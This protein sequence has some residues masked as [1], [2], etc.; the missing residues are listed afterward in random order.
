MSVEATTRESQTSTPIFVI[1]PARSGSTLLRYLL[2][3]HPDVSC[4]AET[5]L[6]FA[7]QAIFHSHSVASGDPGDTAKWEPVAIETCRI[8]AQRT[9][10]AAAQRDNKP[11]WCD[12]SLSTAEHASL[13]A[14][15][16]PDVQFL[17]LY[18]RCSDFVASALEAC[19]WGLANFGFEPFVRDTPTNL[20]L[21]LVRYWIDRVERQITAEQHH[22]AS[23]L[24]ITY[25]SLVMDHASTLKAVCAF[26]AIEYRAEFFRDDLV[27][28]VPPTF[29]PED[30]KIAFA[31]RR[32]VESVGRGEAVP[33]ESLVPPD[34][35]TKVASLE[36]DLGLDKCLDRLDGSASNGG[37]GGGGAVRS[38]A[39]IP[40]HQALAAVVRARFERYG[41]ERVRQI[42]GHNHPFTATILLEDGAVCA[43]VAVRDGTIVDD[44]TP[45]EL[46]LRVP[47]EVLVALLDGVLAPPDVARRGLVVAE[48]P[49]GSALEPRQAF[50]SIRTLLRVISDRPQ[51]AQEVL[52]D[53]SYG[54]Q[55]P[56]ATDER[57][58]AA[59]PIFD[60]V[61]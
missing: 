39:P 61:V 19:P 16:F 57:D 58:V 29:G 30:Y 38:A 5:N 40:R 22:A 33:I 7:F 42:S 13:I 4:P 23:A 51:H 27:F 50:V 53:A 26:L 18:R 3:A 28:D 35:A 60:I 32:H 36:R 12:K 37:G 20:V 52:G 8:L 1:T 48:H 14:K 44:C 9:L 2:R 10:G 6:A 41:A 46:T 15:I 56:A 21:A 24:R 47:C 25:E 17:V 11:R 55:A 34:L 45:M 43:S 49:S 31:A 54:H 59:A